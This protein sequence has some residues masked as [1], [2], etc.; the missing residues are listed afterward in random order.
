[1]STTV[2]V[3]GAVALVSLV[4][5]VGSLAYLHVAPTGLSPIRNAV[6]QFGITRYKAGYRAATISFGVAG[7]ALAVGVGG[8]VHGNGKA[9]VVGFLVI[10]AIGRLIISWFPMDEP[11]TP[12]TSTGSAHGIIAI[13]TFGSATAAAFRLGSVLTRD[14]TWHTLAPT[15]TG[16]GWAML[17]CIL[18][19][20]LG[21]TSPSLHSRF[22]AVERG[23]YLA[24]IGWFA[25]FAVACVH[26]AGRP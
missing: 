9:V 26:S 2:E 12:R 8:A 23:L 1:V 5:T 15:S 6:S 24:M 19:M 14:G 10:F 3:A 21:R 13:V 7:I 18:G 20:V 17:V 16:F 4:A 25:V 22:G 11:G